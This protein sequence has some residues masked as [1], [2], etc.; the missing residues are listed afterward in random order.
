MSTKYNLTRDVTGAYQ[1]GL[2]I[3]YDNFGAHL[4]AST[5][6]SFVVPD[7]YPWFLAIIGIPAG[8]TIWA[9]NTTTAVIPASTVAAT[10]A[11]C[12]MREIYVKG[13]STLSLITDTS[14]GASVSVSFYVTNFYVN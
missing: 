13:G 9:D 8:A 6:Q 11:V 10:T 12:N 2:P 7:N 3:A 4:A 14:G 5:A 1:F